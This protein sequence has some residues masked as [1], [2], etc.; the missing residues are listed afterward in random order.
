MVRCVVD[1]V[2]D[3]DVRLWEDVC[4]PEGDACWR[5]EEDEAAV[6]T[7]PHRLPLIL[8]LLV[9]LLFLLPLVL[10]LSLDCTG[11]R[12]DRG[13]DEAWLTKTPEDCSDELDAEERPEEVVDVEGGIGELEL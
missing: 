6:P 1:I 13:R 7:R 10:L 2:D 5:R 8:L 11:D 4:V 12:L 9:M 3:D